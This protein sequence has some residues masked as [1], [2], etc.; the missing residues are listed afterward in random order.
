[1]A[2]LK[3]IKQKI[4][5]VNKTRQVTKA[6]EAVS[7]VKMRK[8]QEQALGARPY[9]LAALTILKRVSS[10][11][12]K[13]RHPLTVLRSGKKTGV[14]VVSS[15]KGLAGSLNSAIIRAAERELKARGITP[16]NSVFFGIGRRGADSFAKRGFDMKERHEN[17][18]DTVAEDTMRETTNQI[19]ALYTAGEISS[20][21]IVYTNFLSTFEQKPVV[22]QLL[23]ISSDAVAEIVAGIAPRRGSFASVSEDGE[24]KAE[25][26]AS[27]TY[28][29]EPSAQEVLA[30][31]LPRL[32]NV[33]MF[34][35]LV[36]AKASEHS[37]RMVAMKSATDKAG[38]LA[39]DLTLAFNKARQAAITGEV[40]E[41]TSGIEAMK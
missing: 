17:V 26:G 13:S 5:A 2:S 16:E 7:A 40:S 27:G 30:A 18:S 38:E 29:I 6:M 3:N 32:V 31:V 25:T 15:D 14:V 36:E 22:R 33:V 34:H 23:P 39:H 28:T 12:E 11:I 24:T 20:C 35:A 37:A 10:S 8:T 4:G 21:I 9:A 1:M 41:I 19:L